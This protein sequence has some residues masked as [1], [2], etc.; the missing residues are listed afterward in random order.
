MLPG[1]G[2]FYFL[3]KEPMANTSAPLSEVGIANMAAELLS[4]HGM[5]TLDENTPLGRFMQ[6]NFGYVR[7]EML[8]AY[9][10]HFAK[11]RKILPV[12]NAAPAFGYSYSYTLPTDCLKLLPLRC[13]GLHN[14]TP[15]P[16]ELE[17]GK[18]LTNGDGNTSLKI[19]YI[20]RETDCS[21]FSPLF[22]R[23]FG[24]RLAL[25]ASV[26]VTGKSNYYDRCLLA[27]QDSMFLAA[28][29]DSLE[30]GTP[31]SQYDSEVLAVRGA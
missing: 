4:D 6:R 29:Q 12:D 2:L 15:I 7:D 9:P 5:A 19:H 11:T 26:R 17:S 28:Q 25:I 31:E 27:Y 21:K 13:G 18:I 3:T 30:R 24:C 8:Q 1:A 10:W 23:A 16:Y 14:G 22:A 20:R